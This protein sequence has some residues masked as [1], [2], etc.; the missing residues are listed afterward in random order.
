MAK[1]YTILTEV[2]KTKIANAAALGRQVKLTKLAVGD[3]NGSEYDPQEDQLSLK[4]ETYSTP[5]SHLGT[6][7]EN[8]N[9]VIAEGMIP[10]D[11]GGWFVREVGIFDEDGDLFAIG[12]YPETYKPTLSEGTGRDLYIRFI[13]VV[14]N[15]EAI[16]IKIDPTV[17]IATK[18]WVEENFASKS[19]ESIITIPGISLDINVDNRDVIYA[20]GSNIYVPKDVTVRCNFLPDD[21]VRKL[22]GEGKVLTRDPWGNEHVFDVNLAT[23][24]PRFT[25][26]N[27]INQGMRLGTNITVGA[28][29]DSITDG[30]DSSG[31]VANPTDGNGN[32][33]SVNYDHSNNGGRGSWFRVFVDNLNTISAKSA[34]KGFNASSSGKKLIDGW[35]NRNFDYGFFQNSAYQNRAPDVLL[36]AMGVNDNG[37]INGNADFDTYLDEFDKIIRKAWG[38]GA[39]VGVVSITNTAKTW[40]YLEGAI[41]RYLNELYRAVEMFDLAKYLEKYR[42]SGSVTSFDLWYDVSNVYDTTHPNDIGQQFLGGAM[43]K[44]LLDN[45]VI[46]V[47]DGSNIVPQTSS[48]VLVRGY[49]SQ[50]DYNPALENVSGGWLDEFKGLAYVSPT[51]ENISCWYFIWCEEND[52]SLVC[53]EPKA[54]TYTSSGRSHSIKTILNDFGAEENSYSIASTGLSSISSYM[55]TKLSRLGYG[56]NLIRVVYDGQPSKAYLP[57]MMFRNNRNLAVIPTTRRRFTEPSNKP[58]SLFGGQDRFLNRRFQPY[59][60][61][62]ELPDSFDGK[63]YPVVGYVKVQVPDSCGVCIFAK[64]L[65]NKGVILMRKDAATITIKRIDGTFIEDVAIDVS[66][67]WEVTWNNKPGG[68][69]TFTVVGTGGTSITRTLPDLSGGTCLFINESAS[70]ATCLV[71]GG[72]MQT[73]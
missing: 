21:D 52:L 64:E 61:R 46:S 60:A 50:V 54:N 37:L 29:G 9:W 11:V 59:D 38:Y 58:I 27:R 43:T 47:S 32:L 17:A 69:G 6:D 73:D 2:G 39:T 22:F 72:V 14:S 4:N 70:N 51:N 34:I 62:D 26:R 1:Y 42:K 15:A 41:K 25:S 23:N 48:D 31:W 66:N 28:L 3:G 56:L 57:I 36:I 44:E 65:A 13:M 53:M 49:P 40:G 19:G 16:D 18:K 24:G 55:T 33:S 35:S 30:A 71:L 12:K 45:Q 7:A 10:V 5:I 8:P 67:A 63:S 20:H 68:E